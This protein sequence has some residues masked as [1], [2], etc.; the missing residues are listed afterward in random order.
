LITISKEPDKVF[1]ITKK[2][3]TENY[4]NYIKSWNISFSVINTK[5]QVEILAKHFNNNTKVN[6]IIL[7]N[8]VR[9]TTIEFVTKTE[10]NK[11]IFFYFVWTVVE[12]KPSAQITKINVFRHNDTTI[13]FQLSRISDLPI[14]NRQNALQNKLFFGYKSFLI[15]V[16][17]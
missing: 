7:T 9:K 10:Q 17:R 16:Y 8:L 15:S 5:K 4:F 13:Q 12:T 11:N 14:S 6:S 2:L 1:F 3:A